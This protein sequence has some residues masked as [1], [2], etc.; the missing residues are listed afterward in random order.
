MSMMD[1]IEEEY[2]I[3]IEALNQRIKE[4]EAKTYSWCN[5]CGG[6]VVGD[7]EHLC[8]KCG[9]LDGKVIFN[10]EIELVKLRQALKGR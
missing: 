1:A 10:P 2:Q 5:T 6:L 9:G 7:V 4:L 3:K 8:D